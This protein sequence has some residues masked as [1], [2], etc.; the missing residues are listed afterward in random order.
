MFSLVIHGRGHPQAM[1]WG[2]NL[3]I[4]LSLPGREIGRKIIGNQG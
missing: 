3:R 1:R 2:R 4:W